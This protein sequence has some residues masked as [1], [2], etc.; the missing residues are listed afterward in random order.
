MNLEK[1]FGVAVV[2]LGVGEQHAR[3]FARNADCRLD[4]L[5]DHDRSRAEALAETL[6]QGKVANDFKSMVT[7][8][9]TDVV[10]IA[11]HDDDHF[12]QAGFALEHGRHVFVEKPLCR[13]V[14]EARALKTKWKDAGRPALESNLV[15]RGAAL[16]RW[17]VPFIRK[18]GLGQI[19]AVDGEYLYGRLHKITDGWRGRV[20]NYSV[21]E[22]G[23]IHML[24]LMIDLLGS[25]PERVW[26]TGNGICTEESDF[27]YNDFVAA[28]YRFP[29]G[30]IGRLTA[31]FGCVHRHQ[32]V[33]RVYGTEGT[34][35][36]DDAGPRLHVSRDPDVAVRQVEENPLPESKGILVSG[37]V[38]LITSG[39]DTTHLAQRNFDL[40]C[41]CVAADQA[42]SAGQEV[43]VTYV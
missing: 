2:G 29:S 22:G 41:A 17:L 25:L 36:Y 42:L 39:A 20:D 5:L 15:L 16:Y 37:F 38:D 27:R 14:D 43:T 40:V 34:F 30:A 7:E 33:L 19:Y 6:G 24:D 1:T 10:A 32:H 4:W 13:T 9:E 8:P 11:S 3:A 23:G 28:T 18:G 35:L 12:S 21:L 31:N 26:A